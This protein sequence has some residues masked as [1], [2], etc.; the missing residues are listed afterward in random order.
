M[1]GYFSV[2]R[3]EGYHEIGRGYGK[4]PMNLRR[5]LIKANPSLCYGLNMLSATLGSEY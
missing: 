4:I 3:S 5:Q 2:C 1:F